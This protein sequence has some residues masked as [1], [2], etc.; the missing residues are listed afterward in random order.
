METTIFIEDFKRKQFNCIDKFKESISDKNI[1]N[2]DEDFLRF[3]EKIVFNILTTEDINEIL[4][5]IKDKKIFYESFYFV[6]LL[7][8]IHIKPYEFAL[9]YLHNI[10]FYDHYY[11][12]DTFIE[13]Y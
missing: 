11:V 7:E 6:Y 9:N 8:Q 5:E 10:E 1:Y 4:E 13:L 3:M 12:I 2:K